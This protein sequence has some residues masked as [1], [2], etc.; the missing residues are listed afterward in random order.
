MLGVNICGNVFYLITG[1]VH[2]A[3]QTK[4]TVWYCVYVLFLWSSRR[5]MSLKNMYVIQAGQKQRI[6]VMEGCRMSWI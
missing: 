3:A 2:S 4:H 6:T 1:L 5:F